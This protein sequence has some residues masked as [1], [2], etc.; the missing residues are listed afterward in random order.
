MFGTRLQKEQSGR[1]ERQLGVRRNGVR[2][3]EKRET[4]DGA[5]CICRGLRDKSQN[6]GAAGR[7]AQGEVG[8]ERKHVRG[9]WPGLF[10]LCL[11]STPHTFQNAILPK[12]PSLIS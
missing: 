12:M 7:M 8:A 3:G 10:Q 2:G 6:Q 1:N 5:S 11:W 4:K 9:L